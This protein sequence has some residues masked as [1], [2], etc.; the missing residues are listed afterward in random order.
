[1]GL[2]KGKILIVE[3]EESIAR[4]E[5]LILEGSYEIHFAS[6]GEQG[7][8]LAKAL[9]PDLIILDLMLPKRGGYD[10]CF[11]IRQEPTLA[12][13]K[14]IMV[15]AK[16]LQVDRDKGMF[17]GADHYITKPFEPEELVSAV[18]THLKT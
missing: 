10:L 18:K 9:M 8:R 14:I 7:L 15:T 6:D 11:N 2:K 5:G 4:A 13:T 3:D 17:V 12:K 16:N 1:M